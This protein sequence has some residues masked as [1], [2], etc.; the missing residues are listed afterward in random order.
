MTVGKE[1]FC[2][3]FGAILNTW[4]LVSLAFFAGVC[5]YLLPAIQ[6]TLGGLQSKVPALEEAVRTGLYL[7]AGILV[8]PW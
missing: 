7:H 2:L 4:F 6:R 1:S 3:R 8:D 5:V